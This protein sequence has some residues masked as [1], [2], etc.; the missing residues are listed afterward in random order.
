VFGSFLLLLCL[1]T[2]AMVSVLVWLDH[3]GLPFQRQDRV[4]RDGRTIGLFKLRTTRATA[5]G[6]RL[7]RTGD[8]LRRSRIDHLPLLI[9]VLKGDL[10]L[11]G[12]RPSFTDGE[13]SPFSFRER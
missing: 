8:L 4:T 5:F 6:P 11:T 9:N 2:L 10:S 13:N 3:A 1:P 7:T 12:P